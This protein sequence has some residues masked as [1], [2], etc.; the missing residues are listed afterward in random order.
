VAQQHD[1]KA[2]PEFFDALASRRKTFEVRKNDRDY[3]LGDVLLLREYAPVPRARDQA[4][5]ES[6][7]KVLVCGKCLRAA[8]W[9]GEF[10]CDNA[11]TADLKILSVGDL[12]KIDREHEDFWSDEKMIEVY[13]DASRDFRT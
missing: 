11:V 10:M 9:Y 6:S 1:L 2:W 13:G 5:C 3:Q 8:C 7:A 12:R 4:C